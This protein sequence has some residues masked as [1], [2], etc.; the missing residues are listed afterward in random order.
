[1]MITYQHFAYLKY[2]Q[3]ILSNGEYFVLRTSLF[4]P[5]SD[6]VNTCA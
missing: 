3:R 6:A 4:G 5:E 2:A 1:M